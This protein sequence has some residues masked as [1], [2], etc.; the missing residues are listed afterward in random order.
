MYSDQSMFVAPL[1][2]DGTFAWCML[3][4]VDGWENISL[5]ATVDY[6]TFG[7]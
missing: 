6:Y 2:K 3:F 4:F 1:Y 5:F 7:N